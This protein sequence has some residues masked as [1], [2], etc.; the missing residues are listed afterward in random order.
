MR[1]NINRPLLADTRRMI[2]RGMISQY[3]LSS[4]PSRM[5]TVVR[6]LT[7]PP[8]HA[9]PYTDKPF[10]GTTFLTDLPTAMAASDGVTLLNAAPLSE[11]LFLI[12]ILHLL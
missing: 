9:L 12:I 10:G 6:L 3:H 4:T 2:D 11:I 8:G 1:Y 5:M 7:A